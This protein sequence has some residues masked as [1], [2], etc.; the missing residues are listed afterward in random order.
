MQIFGFILRWLASSIGMYFCISWFGQVNQT[1]VQFE[2]GWMLYALAGFI[3]AI[4]NSILKPII[5]IFAL[6]LAVLTL[7][8]STFIINTIIVLITIHLIP[9][10]EMEVWP[11]AL[12]SIIMSAINATLN[13][14]IK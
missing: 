3:F 13:F 8:L 2:Q 5:K 6:P 4:L 7:G 10:V 11:A 1:E 12:S 14:L 9:G